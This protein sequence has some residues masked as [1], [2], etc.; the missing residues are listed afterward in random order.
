MRERR[1]ATGISLS[2]LYFTFKFL[3]LSLLR[4]CAKV[5]AMQK[6]EGVKNILRSGGDHSACLQLAP[7]CP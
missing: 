2:G 7:Q 1:S 4:S 3:P 5:L 6:L